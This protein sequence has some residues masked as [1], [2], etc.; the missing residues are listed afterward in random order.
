MA[1]EGVAMETPAGYG[2][3]MGERRE[4]SGDCKAKVQ[5]PRQ[6]SVLSRLQVLWIYLHSS[7][8]CVRS[9]EWARCSDGEKDK[10]HPW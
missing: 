2:M 9:R 1:L 5:E 3:E 4:C 7:E 10:C 6:V 8:L